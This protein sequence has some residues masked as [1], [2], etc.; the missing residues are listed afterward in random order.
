MARRLAERSMEATVRLESAHFWIQVISSSLTCSPFWM[1][2]QMNS[3]WS[4]TLVESMNVL[5]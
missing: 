5:Q 1:R 3:A 2:E 4:R